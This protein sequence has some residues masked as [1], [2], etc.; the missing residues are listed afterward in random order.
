[1]SFSLSASLRRIK[2]QGTRDRLA[3]RREADLLFASRVSL[4][5]AELL[6]DTV[7]YIDV[8][9]TRAPPEVKELLVG[10]LK[11]HSS[12]ALGEL[13][14]LFGRLDPADPRTPRTLSQLRGAIEDIP[15][16]RLQ[17]P[18][19][20][21]FGEAGMLAGLAARLGGRAH[22]VELFNDALLLLQAAEAGRILLTRNLRDFDIL[23]QLAP[24]AQVI[25]YRR[26]SGA[27]A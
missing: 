22:E 17:V 6:L 3:R 13:T 18:S 16:H 15:A 23:Q 20:R 21:A 1:M 10:R 11:M 19:L 9:Q 4:A 27:G 5:G 24:H 12:V 7:V 2:P 8:L 25:F 26:A 14:H